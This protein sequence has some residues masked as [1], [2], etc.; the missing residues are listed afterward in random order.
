MNWNQN[1][2]NVFFSFIDTAEIHEIGTERERVF[3][4][5]RGFIINKNNMYI[6]YY[7]VIVTI[8]DL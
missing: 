3:F 1:L 6:T 8:T 7:S 2:K 5:D 4:N